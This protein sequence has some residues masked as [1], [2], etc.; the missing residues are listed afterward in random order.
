M[1]HKIEPGR[2]YRILTLQVAVPEDVPDA[3]VHGSLTAL[4]GGIVDNP[5]GAVAD[6]R[7]FC[8]EAEPVVIAPK[9]CHD[10]EIFLDTEIEPLPKAVM[11]DLPRLYRWQAH[12]LDAFRKKFGAKSNAEALDAIDKL[13]RDVDVVKHVNISELAPE[14]RAAVLASLDK[15]VG[16]TEPSG[17]GKTN[18]LA[19]RDNPEFDG[20][21]AAHPAWW[22]GEDHGLRVACAKINEILDG[23]EAATKP[24]ISPQCHVSQYTYQTFNRVKK[25]AKTLGALAT[26]AGYMKE[27]AE[28]G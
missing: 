11:E 24:E 22:R 15:N 20:T 17:M 9:D 13:L 21:D 28:Y 16:L 27:R 6:W 18:L 5:I 25:L 4:L 7:Y 8:E 1:A 26:I 3:K 14:R 2:K 10:G 23:D 19:L 12:S